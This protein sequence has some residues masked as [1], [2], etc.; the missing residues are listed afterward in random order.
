MRYENEENV[1]NSYNLLLVM[2]DTN[3]N[4]LT[5]LLGHLLGPEEGKGP[6]G[7]RLSSKG[8]YLLTTSSPSWPSFPPG[9]AIFGPRLDFVCVMLKQFMRR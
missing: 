4:Q 8:L 6:F 7:R 5:T 3:K 1:K 2:D 9:R